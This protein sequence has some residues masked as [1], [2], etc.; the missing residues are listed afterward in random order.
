[1]GDKKINKTANAPTFQKIISKKKRNNA[2]NLNKYEKCDQNNNICQQDYFNKTTTKLITTILNFFEN[3]DNKI[4]EIMNAYSNIFK[5]K[6]SENI[7]IFKKYE[8]IFIIF[9]LKIYIFEK[10]INPKNKN[11]NQL[12]YPK[13]FNKFT[14]TTY[15]NDEEIIFMEIIFPII[16]NEYITNK[17]TRDDYNNFFKTLKTDLVR[18][19]F[20][21]NRLNNL[22]DI[23]HVQY[24]FDLKND[25][26]FDE[27]NGLVNKANSIMPIPYEPISKIVI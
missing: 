19:Y 24:F 5:K 3:Y 18:D 6:Q 22:K 14:Y 11:I 10:I 20:E 17:I 7:E 4:N 21:N 16:Q 9:Y 23:L 1:M 2:N 12:E 26:N 15:N 25:F 8:N 13:I 27:L